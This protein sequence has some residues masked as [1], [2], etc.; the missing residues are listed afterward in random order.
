MNDFNWTLCEAADWWENLTGIEKDTVCNLQLRKVWPELFEIGYA[1][2]TH[3]HYKHFTLFGLIAHLNDR[4]KWTREEIAN[5]LEAK[6]N[7][8]AV[9]QSWMQS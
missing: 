6:W 4:H 7:P 3:P 2:P 1:C 5:W 9:Y 8:E